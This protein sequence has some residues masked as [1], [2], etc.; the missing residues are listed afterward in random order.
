MKNI[1]L[2]SS[3]LVWFFVAYKNLR[4]THTH[5]FNLIQNMWINASD[6]TE[7]STTIAGS[8]QNGGFCGILLIMYLINT[9]RKTAGGPSQA[10]LK[11]TVLKTSANSQDSLCGE[12]HFATAL[13]VSS[14]IDI[15]REFCKILRW[16]TF[17]WFSKNMWKI[18]MM[19]FIWIYGLKYRNTRQK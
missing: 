13:Q 5:I 12:F 10:F 16:S 1:T 3:L 7:C 17:S 4:H 14:N 11:I 8:P 6:K 9:L 18:A 19:S 2:L 15:Y